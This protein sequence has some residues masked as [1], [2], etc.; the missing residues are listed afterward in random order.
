MNKITAML[1]AL[2]MVFAISV[3]IVSA[4]S[5]T[6]SSTAVVGGTASPSITEYKFELHDELTAPGIQVLPVALGDKAVEIYAI[7]SDPNGAADINTVDVKVWYPL[8]I[9][10][11]GG[12]GLQNYRPA[13]Y[14][15][16][17]G[18]EAYIGDILDTAITEGRIT[19][20]DKTLILG[21]LVND[22]WRFYETTTTLKYYDVAGIYTVEVVAKDKAGSPPVP[23][24]N[25]FEY[26][27]IKSIGVDFPNVN[28]GT[29]IPTTKQIVS[30]DRDLTTTTKP[31]IQN[32]GNDP[33]KLKISG[34]DLHGSDFQNV[35]YATTL[36]SKV[37]GVASYAVA[38]NG[39]A[40]LGADASQEQNL[41]TA[42][43]IFT[44]LISPDTWNPVNQIFNPTT[45]LYTGVKV[46]TGVRQID[47]SILAPYGTTSDTYTGSFTL[48]AIPEIE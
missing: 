29:I 9:P 39:Y 35:I 3:P 17:T 26:I 20:A 33:F 44:P 45:K 12:T 8:V 48:E 7:V 42:G 4:D 15:P 10:N 6:R 30:G 31:T 14:I 27:S 38:A 18:N 22:E 32:E 34:T 21:H 1:I 41:N 16:Y 24:T 40:T 23:F 19:S 36:D 25:T 5:E 28:Y 2:T 47:F 43:I 13:T 46:N 11:P 37:Y